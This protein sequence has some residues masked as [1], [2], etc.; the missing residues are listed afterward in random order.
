MERMRKP[1]QGVLNIVR[2]NW[3]FFAIGFAL[4]L[5][6]CGFA[7]YLDNQYSSLIFLLAALGF[8][9]IILP[10]AVSYY[11]Y[12][13]SLLYTLNFIKPKNTDTVIVNI[14]AG[15]DET[16]ALLK[17]KFKDAELIV[18]DFYDPTMH[19][20][21]SIK[22]ARKAY[23]AFPN[24][25]QITTNY[26]PLADNCAEKIFL[27][28]AAHEIRQEKERIEFFKELKRVL[29][30]EGEIYVTEHLRDIPNFLAYNIGAFHFYS[31]ASW[32]RIFNAANL[33]V[34]QETKTTA[35]I[36]NFILSKN[37]NTF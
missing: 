10:L 22:R 21:V 35:F 31:K 37:G 2:F 30:P 29:K 17:E 32:L 4:I 8:C 24:T 20:E 28:F 9:A 25:K 1:F 6:T 34:K 5:F 36:T 12:D 15:F 13:S 7:I 14:N 3:H 19:T 27:I 23:S 16:S 26:I 33:K 18:L 11:V